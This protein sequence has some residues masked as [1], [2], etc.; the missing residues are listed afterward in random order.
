MIEA[1]IDDLTW[2]GIKFD[3]GYKVGGESGPY[4]QSQRYH[5]YHRYCIHSTRWGCFIHVGVQ[6]E[7]LAAAQALHESNQSPLYPGTR[8]PDRPRPIDD[9]DK[10]PEDEVDDRTPT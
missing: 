6:E 10:L 2:F 4:L 5:H 8:R 7:V 1:Q 9:L 3:Q